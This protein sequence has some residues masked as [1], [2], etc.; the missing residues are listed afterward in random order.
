MTARKII[1]VLIIILVAIPVLFGITW[2]VGLV[3]ASVS[4]EFLSDLPREIIAELPASADAVFK[5]AQDK[6]FIDDPA[7]RIW[8]QAAA[9][10]GTSM[11]DLMESS[12]MTGWMQGELSA[13][14]AR[15]GEIL[16]G[17]SPM[18]AVT[19]D[20]RPLKKALLAPAVDKFLEG[21]VAN[22]PPC[23]ESGLKA[24]KDLAAGLEPGRD[25]PACSPDPVLAKAALL[26]AR[27]RAVREM[28][29]SVQVFE[30]VQPFPFH[31][32]GIT[33]GVTM[34]SY[35]L[36]LIPALFIL[37]GV[38]VGQNTP[39]G[40]LRWSG[41]SVLAGSVPVLILAIGIKKFSGWLLHGGM[42]NWQSPWTSDL[43][44]MVV[45]KLNWIPSRVIN[46]LFSPVVSV[47]AVV[48]VLGIVLL[49]LAQ[50]S[51]KV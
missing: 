25:L 37:I 15:V 27:N 32:F 36:F 16:R 4:P 33:R 40:R 13:S 42:F 23:D 51:R 38:L 8:F 10:T 47:A 39:A 43:G 50:S 9:K 35:F 18:E 14:L 11:R 5:A 22:L 6:D 30:G 19:I 29:D 1:G 12:G 3:K 41:I 17:E 7:T 31:R 26:V 45:D 49:A 34:A 2:A 46:G 28:H 21:T 44:R 48:T 20:M 24:W